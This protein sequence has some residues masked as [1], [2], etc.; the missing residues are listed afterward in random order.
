MAEA[1]VKVEGDLHKVI[2]Y[3]LFLK[4][5]L[6][7]REES[8]RKQF[9]FLLRHYRKIEVANLCFLTSTERGEDRGN[10]LAL[11]ITDSTKT[12]ACVTADKQ[13][14]NIR[15]DVPES[16]TTD[17]AS[18]LP[19]RPYLLDFRAEEL[20]EKKTKRDQRSAEHN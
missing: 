10:T 2:G 16:R 19:P 12:V 15:N 7:R 8:S 1:H 14:W 20:H 18:P 17:G 5:S 13:A 4:P 11:R 3:Q 9:S 6:L